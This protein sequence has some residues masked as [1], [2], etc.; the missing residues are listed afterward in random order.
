[1]IDNTPEYIHD[2]ETLIEVMTRPR[3]EMIDFI[4]KVKS[5]LVILGAGGKMGPT[6][7]LLAQRAAEAAG[8]KLEIIAVDLFHDPTVRDRFENRGI[9]TLK[10]DLMKPDN[11]DQLPD[12][13][14]LIYLVGMKFG[15]MDN[16]SLTWAINALIPANVCQRYPHT[17]IVA[18]STGNIYPFV[19]ISSGGATEEVDPHPLGEYA[20]SCLARERVF[21]YFSQVNGT[22]VLLVRLNYAL[23]LRYGVL[24]DIAQ[25]IYKNQPMDV[26]MGYLNCI[27]Q[28]DSNEMI[29]RALSHV[30]S[31]AKELNLTGKDTLSV[32]ELA[33][34]FGELMDKDVQIIGEEADTAL[35]SNSTQAFNLLGV[36]P[37]PVDKVVNW[38]AHWITRGGSDLG[39][40]SHF[41]V[42]NGDF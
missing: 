9:K 15:T 5:P 33:Y 22:P 41:E 36:P 27:W 21:Q 23:D 39:K 4:H 30:S 19:P 1:M 29:L 2:E 35:L 37:T 11:L 40:P 13:E 8:Y 25:K 20:N 26:T 10:A 17:R 6:M 42:R 31:P 28:G 3:P 16:P 12:T 38:T 24:V 14:N 7:T 34:R 32:R 18:L